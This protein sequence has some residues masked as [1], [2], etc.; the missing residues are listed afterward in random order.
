MAVNTQSILKN[1]SSQ[2]NPLRGMTK[3]QIDQMLEQARRGND[4][5]LQVAFE[6]VEQNMPI[7]GICIQKRLAGVQ[8]RK[9]DIIPVD[10]SEEALKQAKT[11]KKYFDFADMKN[12]DG[13][14]EAIRH[15]ATAT[16]RG[17]AAV[18]PFIDENGF[19]LKILNNW[20]V[21]CRNNRLYWNPDPSNVP[22][23]F[24]DSLERIPNLELCWVKENLPIDI[25][26]IQIYLRQL[27]GEEQWARAVEKYG[28]AQ[29]LLEVPDGTPDESMDQW[30]YRANRILEGGSGAMPSGTKVTQLDGARGQDPFTSYIEHQMEMISIL[31]TGGTLA[32]I[33]GGTG[34]GSNLADVQESQFQNLV[35]YDCK[36]IANTLSE[37]AVAKICRYLGQKQ[38]CRFTYIE[39]TV[40]PPEKYIEMAKNLKDLGCNI[41]IQKLKDI[42]KLDFISDEDSSIWQ[43]AGD[44]K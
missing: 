22:D 27:V 8:S 15:L 31:A 26:G 42:V 20:N 11:V 38:L 13:L 2:M 19:R 12:V 36:R 37:V 28:V 6:A 39:E 41:D 4:A 24:E 40:T 21:L 23:D 1:F 43:P 16:F 30:T 9:W 44:S 25:P 29:I 32:T 35:S 7:F 5:R 10:D 34:L 18:K 3:I 33:G 14:S 17:R